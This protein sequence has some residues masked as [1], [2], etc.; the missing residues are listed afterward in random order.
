MIE[1]ARRFTRPAPEQFRR[2]APWLC[3]RTL[4]RRR[5]AARGVTDPWL[6]FRSTSRIGGCVPSTHS[7]HSS[8]AWDG[9]AYGKARFGRFASNTESV[10]SIFH[11]AFFRDTTLAIRIS[12][13]SYSI[14]Q[15]DPIHAG[16]ASRHS[17]YFGGTTRQRFPL[18]AFTIRRRTIGVRPSTS[19]NASSLGQF[20]G[21]SFMKS[22]LLRVSGK[23]AVVTLRFRGHA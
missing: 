6:L 17:T 9:S 5:E 20:D 10:S 4:G 22:G 14:R 8:H 18:S 2:S 15:L 3:Q 19:S 1:P 13:S 7:L 11:A 23:A 16:R 21:F 12:V